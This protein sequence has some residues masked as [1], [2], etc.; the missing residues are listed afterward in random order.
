MILNKT[1]L[2]PVFKTHEFCLPRKFK[3][4]DACQ[5]VFPNCRTDGY[6]AVKQQRQV[7]LEKEE[8]SK[9]SSDISCSQIFS[10][11]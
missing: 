10:Y 2:F 5:V 1:I 7:I 6:T 3:P 11:S 8:Q 4:I 9:F